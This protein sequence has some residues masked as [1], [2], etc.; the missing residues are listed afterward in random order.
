MSSTTSYCITVDTTF[1]RVAIYTGSKGKWKLKKYWKCGTGIKSRPTTKGD[2]KLKSYK[3]ARIDSGKISYWNFH[4]Y[5]GSLGF[6]SALTK[7][8]SR[9][10]YSKPLSQQLGTNISHGCVRLHPNNAKYVYNM[11]NGTAIRIK[12]L[13]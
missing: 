1:N 5:G 9:T 3:R 4:G 13:V 10:K 8:G 7:R 12:G 6:H 2:F 11:P